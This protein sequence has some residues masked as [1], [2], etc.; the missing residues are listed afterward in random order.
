MAV[1]QHGS[2]DRNVGDTRVKTLYLVCREGLSAVFPAMVLAPIAAIQR[3]GV[4]VHLAVLTPVGELVR[5]R[6]SRR[7]R[8]LAL[9]ARK[10]FGVSM[11]RLLSAPTRARWLWSDVRAVRRWVARH[12]N[13]LPDPIVLH[14][15]GPYAASLALKVRERYPQLRVLFDMRGITFAENL[16]VRGLPDAADTEVMLDSEA[17]ALYEMERRVAKAAD[18]V[19]CVASSAARWLTSKFG[20]AA[21][22][23]EVVQNPVDVERFQESAGRP[24]HARND[25][26]ARGRFVV[27]YCGTL[28]EWQQFGLA[29]ELYAMLKKALPQA[30]FLAITTA[31]ERLGSLLQH[32]GL[33]PHDYAVMQLP[34]HRVAEYL[35]AADLGL[36]TRGL[37]RPPRLEDRLSCPV[38]FAEYLAA[39]VP[40]VLGRDIGDCSRIATEETVGVVL[41]CDATAQQQ[42]L[43]AYA[44]H[45]LANRES[46][47]HHCIEIARRYHDVGAAAERIRALYC[48][49]VSQTTAEAL[50][51]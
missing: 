14:C 27:S 51:G 46:L 22:R 40:V 34:Y 29:V 32:A 1:T 49:I 28:R 17:R 16:L 30:F 13:G 50:G 21:E 26:G 10:H 11:T 5:P 25:I 20:V 15:R 7:W 18:A 19:I 23:I 39:G 47:R 37:G 6:G 45:V 2:S 48:T 35:A 43:T 12:A 9:D 24:E 31:P 42:E 38:K 36:I 3:R 4:D 33:H 41:S 44:Q 8:Q